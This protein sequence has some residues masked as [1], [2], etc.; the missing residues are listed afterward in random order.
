MTHYCN[1]WYSK[2]KYEFSTIHRM[3]LKYT[4]QLKGC[5][6]N[7]KEERE[8]VQTC[9]LGCFILE[10]WPILFCKKDKKGCVNPQTGK[11][12]I[13]KSQIRD[14]CFDNNILQKK[15]CSKCLCLQTAQCASHWPVACTQKFQVCYTFL[16][17]PSTPLLPSH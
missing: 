13:Y 11:C 4:A 1:T 7:K 16:T 2:R 6:M 15:K 8:A 14:H 12:F 3:F 17:S 10:I 9:S 5:F